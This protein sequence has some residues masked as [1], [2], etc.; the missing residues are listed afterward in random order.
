MK[1]LSLFLTLLAATLFSQAQTIEQIYHFSQPV[2]SE[3]DGYQQIGL[4]DCLPAGI[5]GEPTLPWQ[6]VSLIL[7]QGQEAVSINVEFYD[8]V[9]LEGSFNLYPYQQPR[10]ISNEKEIPFAKKESIYRSGN[11]YP[12]HSFSN[13]NTQY[14]NG[15]AFA[16]SGFTPMQ[17]VPATGKVSYAQTVK[18]SI[19]TT[20]SRDDHSRKLWLTPENE[21]SIKRLAQNEN[22]LNTYNNRGRAIGGYDM[23]VITSEEWIPR[24]GEYLNLYNDKGIRTRIVSLEEIYASTEGIDQPE[25]IRNYIIQEYED[26]GISI[27]SLGGDVSI[28]PF[29]FLYCWAQEGDED[30][31]PSDMYYACLDGTL[32]D[33]GDDRWGEVGEDDLLPELSIGRLPFNNEVQFNNIMHKTFSYL[34]TPVLGEFT[35]PILGAEHLG[36]GYYGSADMERLIGVNNDYDY[37]TI[38]YPE[39]YNFKRYYATPRINWSSGDFK[40]VICSGGQYVHHVGHANTDYVAGWYSSTITDNY[41]SA[42][43]GINH[44]YMIFHSHGCICGNFPASCILEKMVTVETGFVVTTGNSRYGW[45]VPWGDGMAAHIHRE[46]VDAYCND[47]IATVGMALREAKIATAPWVTM[48]GEE[49]GCLRWNIYCLNVLGDGALAPWFE[50]PFTPNVVYEQGIAV[51]ATSTTVHVR[52]FDQPL[53]N[54]RVSLF[55]GETLLGFGITDADGNAELTFDPALETVGEMQLIVTGQSAWPQTFEVTGFDGSIPFVYGDIISFEGEP[56]SG[57]QGLW[58]DGNLYNKGNATAYNVHAAVTSD[59]EYINALEGNFTIDEFAP[60][61]TMQDHRL[62]AIDIADNIPDQTIFT[63]SLTTYVGEEAHTTQKSFLALAPNLQFV[64]FEIVETQGDGNG[65]VD[66]G[67]QGIIRITGKNAG[68]AMAPNAYM[69]VDYTGQG[70][71]FDET[72]YP[73]GDI[74]RDGNFT[75]DINIDTD[76]D[77]ISGTTFHVDLGLHTGAYTTDYNYSFGVGVA[78]ETFESADFNFV[79]WEHAGDRH[80]F[81]TDEEAHN[82]TFSARSGDIA[83]N[84]TSYLIAYAE[85]L[86]DSEISFWFK[87]STEFHKDIFAF[88]IDGKKKDW[89]SGE[90]DWTY[91]SFEFEA[92]SHVFEWIYDKNLSGQAGNDCVWID[93]ITFPH[94]CIITNVEERVRPKTNAI[95]PN[96]TT[97][98]FTMELVEES[99]ISIFNALGQVVRRL[100]NVSGNQQIDLSNAPKGLYYVRIQSGSNIETTKLIVD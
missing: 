18:V 3:R 61:S 73:I 69:T 68:H 31:L 13:V 41:F 84:E 72:T 24:F 12:T 10:P 16:F 57:A 77:I 96:P 82:G 22:M 27:V 85:V 2:V 4:Q 8:F 30:Q 78:I 51:G 64:D 56:Q 91:V 29:R 6:S 100:D 98:S 35:S 45:Y 26:N 38:G 32:N 14:L 11:I 83:D 94:A 34:Q 87:T 60:N 20:T 58:V 62:G 52:H 28:V 88:F 97:G 33:D 15:V 76:Y 39:D 55:D 67:E 50:E 25:Q 53:D 74:D 92:G 59:C 90:T 81:I 65:F 71:H 66:P 37:T 44:N 43:D 63:L 47:H 46:F 79:E 80:W 48:Y 21:A 99:N 40:R 54:F 19:E 9:E 93:D 86:T 7:P 75:V 5:V 23:L 49:N 89:W 17:Y 95:Y 42:N 1:K 70:V 36:D